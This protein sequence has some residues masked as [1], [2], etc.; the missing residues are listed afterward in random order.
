MTRM[1]TELSVLTEASLP[2]RTW[3]ITVRILASDITERVIPRTS[4][5]PP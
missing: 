5:V 2:N 1:P 4:N 3:G